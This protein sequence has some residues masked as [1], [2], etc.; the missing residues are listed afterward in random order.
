MDAQF[1]DTNLQLN[2]IPKFLTVSDTKY[3]IRGSVTTPENQQEVTS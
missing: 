3:Y 2:H 1:T